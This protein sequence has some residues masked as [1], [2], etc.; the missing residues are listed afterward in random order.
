MSR[1]RQNLT[2]RGLA[3][4]LQAETG[5]Y[6][7]A[8]RFVGDFFDELSRRIAEDGEVRL[9]GFGVFRCRVK[10][11]RT[12]RNPKTGEPAPVSARRVATF[13]PSGALREAMRDEDE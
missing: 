2:R 3:E 6:A 10:K 12:A 11:A 1:D 9:R 4:E 8:R 5:S 13:I 7:D